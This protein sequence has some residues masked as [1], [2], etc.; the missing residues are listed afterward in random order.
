MSSICKAWRGPAKG[1]GKGNHEPK[2]GSGSNVYQE[3]VDTPGGRIGDSPVHRVAE[4]VAVDPFDFVW[5]ALRGDE[6][7]STREAQIRLYIERMFTTA[8]AANRDIHVCYV[9]V[10]PCRLVT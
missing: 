2:S 5:S 7:W 8:Q 9:A 1:K 6:V 3:L 10:G 4:E